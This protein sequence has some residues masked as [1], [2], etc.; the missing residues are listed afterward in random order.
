[1]ANSN[2]SDTLMARGASAS[3]PYGDGTQIMVYGVHGTKNGPGNVE[4]VTRTIANALN[5]TTSGPVIY[6]SA[7]SWEQHS[8]Y[9]NNEEG[10]MLASWDLKKHVLHS[11]DTN[12][13]NGT[14]DR[15]KPLVINLVGFSHGGNV[16]IQAVDD[17][18]EELKKRGLNTNTAIHL[19]TLSTPA[20]TFTVLENPDWAAKAARNDGVRFAH[21]HFSVEGDGVIVTANGDRFYNSK[22]SKNYSM[23]GVGNEHPIVNHGL[24]QENQWHM[25]TIASTM[26]VRFRGLAPAG[27]RRMADA[28][29][30]SEDSSFKVAQEKSVVNNSIANAKAPGFEGTFLEKH[31]IQVDKA[32]DGV[33]LAGKN[34]EDVVAAVLASSTKAGFDVKADMSVAQSTKNPD[35][36]IAVQGQGPSALRADAV[37]IAR[38]QTGAAQHLSGTLAQQANVQLLA[39]N[40]EPAEQAKARAV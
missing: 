7:F 28:S 37:E 13:K 12:L 8:G 5:R 1:M 17:I 39:A 22:I 20:Y 32:L 24:P 35:Q 18:T 30:D 38:V 27:T 19:T 6:N 10:R 11:I 31:A 14:L 2:D 33:N 26:A 25:E 29:I 15:N 40:I 3:K 36:L 4:N 21:S 34:K 16:A 23:P 9:T